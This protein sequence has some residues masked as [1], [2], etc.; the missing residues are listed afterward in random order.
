MRLPARL[1]LA[2][3]G[4]AAVL[5]IAA[6]PADALEA[7]ELDRTADSYRSE[8]VEAAAD[9]DTAPPAVELFRNAK[10]AALDGRL[11]DAVA[12]YQLLVG[13]RPAD[14]DAWLRLA[15]V[16]AER[17]PLSPLGLAAAYNA[18][19]LAEGDALRRADALL[20]IAEALEDQ[21]RYRLATEVFD[22]LS[23]L[24][25][26]DPTFAERRDWLRRQYGFH[27]EETTVAFE[28]DRP[29][30]CLNFSDP[31]QPARL[32]HYADYVRIAPEVP[33]E[34]LA[35]DRALC[36][37]GVSHGER[38]TVTVLS[39]LP[40]ADGERLIGDDVFAR[41]VDEREPQVGF[42][43]DTY[44]LPRGG[45]ATAPLTT[46][47]VAEVELQLLRINDRGLMEQIVEDRIGATVDGYDIREIAENRGE[48]IWQGEMAIE[49]VANRSVTTGVPLGELVEDIAPGIYILAARDADD[50]ERW[51]YE[52]RGTQWVVLSDLGLVTYTGHDGL[53]VAVRSLADGRALAGV[54]VRL[55]A[56]N[57]AQLGEAV[58]DADGLA[59]FEAGLVAGTGGSRPGAVLAYADGADAEDFNFLA[60]T[61]PAFDLSDRGVSGRAEPGPLDA[62]LYTERSVYRP[63]ET[64]HLTTLLRDERADALPG[65]PITVTLTR[66]D[67]IEA[68][69]VR[70]SDQGDGG[71]AAALALSDSAR[72]GTWTAAAFVDPDG[73]AIGRVS[74]QVEDF[75]PLRLR[76]DLEPAAEAI[77]PGALT[78]IDVTA[79][80]LY[81]APAVGLPGEAELVLSPAARPFIAD[82]GDWTSWR[83]GL[84]Q[85][86]LEPERLWLDLPATDAEGASAVPVL[87]D[88]L[89]D[90]TLPLQAEIRT[91]LFDVGGRPV[92]RAVTLPVQSGD[93]WIGL[94]AEAGGAFAEDS[95]AS[96]EVI[97]LD[98]D[99]ARTAADALRYQL[100][101]EV[102][103]Y[104]WF[105][106]DGV[107]D[108]RVVVRDRVL[109]VGEVAVAADGPAR[110]DEP[111]DWG[112]YRLDVFEAAGGAAS[113]VRFHAG[114][115]ARP[116]GEETPDTL[117]VTVDRD[118]YDTGDTL[119]VHLDAPF[120]G[121]ALVMVAND[122]LLHAQNVAIGE[123][124]AQLAIPVGEDW[125]VGAYVLATGFRPADADERARGPGRAVGVAWFALDTAD[126]T[127]DVA[128][129]A[130]A[131]IRPR[132]DIT[133]PVSVGGLGEGDQAYVTLAAVDEGILLLTDFASPDP[134]DHYFG[135]RALGL[136][137][138]DAYG[139]LIVSDGRRGRV[140]SGGDG[141]QL[142]GL[143][144]RIVE[145]V[146]LFSGIVPVGADGSAEIPLEIPD[147]NGELRLMA[148]AWTARGIG[149][150]SQPLTVRDP[151]VSQVALPRFLAPDDRAAIMLSLHNVDGPA[152]DYSVAVTGGGAVTVPD[153]GTFV[154]PLGEDERY[155]TAVPLSAETLGVGEITLALAGPDDF[156]ITRRWQIAVRPPQPY[157]TDRLSGLLPPG[158]ALVVDE[159][160]AQSY[161]PGTT[162][163]SASF[164]TRPN[165]DVPG[166]LRQLDGYA[167]GCLEQ[168]VSRALP[169][170][171][172][173]EVAER[174][175]DDYRPDDIRRR[176]QQ[177]VNRT[178]AM[179]QRGGSFGIWGPFGQTNPWLDAYAMD[180]LTRA[181]AEGFDVPDSA[182][183]L[184]LTAL[185]GYVNRWDTRDE[186]HDTAAAALYTLAR[187]DE[188]SV[189]DLRY[190]A[191]TCTGRFRTP[192]ASAQLAA[193]LAAYGETERSGTLFAEASTTERVQPV[194]LTHTDYGSGLRDQAALVA[195]QAE[196]GRPLEEVLSAADHV[197]ALF[198]D[199]RYTSTQE[200]AWLLMAAHALLDTQDEMLLSIDGA[201]VPPTGA[202]VELYPTAAELAA[203]LRVVNDGEDPV[204]R[205]ITVR[206][207]PADPL[208]A[209]SNG[210]TIAREY[211]TLDGRVIDPT[212]EPVRQN[213]LLVVVLTGTK[214]TELHQDALIVDRLPAGFEIENPNIG[215]GRG[216][217][218]L[219]ASLDLSF[220][221]H[222]EQR[223]DRYVAALTLWETLETFRVAYLVRAVTPGD[224]VLPGPFVEDMYRPAYNARGE[225]ARVTVL[226]HDG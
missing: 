186:C 156:A 8:L 149:G 137:M 105:S 100:V 63:G 61:G 25:P 199:R 123:D 92:N 172:L 167:Y 216:L 35:E 45:A 83:F 224:F 58:S 119:S 126:R 23:R 173:S 131:E 53:H 165:F 26:E 46:V 79:D 110:I 66:P 222:V 9:L 59:L 135:R 29:Q 193:A 179:Q 99:G 192:V 221:E 177:A 197:G 113:S 154:L 97:A 225:T 169:M 122:R 139:R 43:G 109:A 55:L 211:R 168:T 171:Y 133:V 201:P 198:A 129:D 203:G 28:R 42:R 41:D 52:P 212:A 75:V 106:V 118:T 74:F 226:P 202:A 44:I 18:Y 81:G 50:R 76:L 33:I 49:S 3:A 200:Q 32:V 159:G 10:Q 77:R 47:N 209:A 82:G 30:I 20:L 16:W 153:A 48:L 101:R 162:T 78:P 21:Q 166:L 115:W 65:V 85:E 1:R 70:L 183:R 213:D 141:D 143:S 120:A 98:G 102:Y 117:Q 114:W 96:V 87:I 144:V 57:N 89:P 164:S 111:V 108:Y 191:D 80:Y 134:T 7:P 24:L 132:Q 68:D 11:G 86:E 158:A 146:A 67:G 38:Y 34:V 205:V 71:Y 181:R 163:V 37:E 112:T 170:L 19:D 124:G 210:L 148:V 27:I 39:G 187:A 12:A 152:G 147:Y 196:A 94:R 160:P 218:D 51:L 69:S 60:L 150:A 125:G 84:V 194:S 189:A 157:V 136:E 207:I 182:W 140:R 95:V 214:A 128:I 54:T 176:L 188:A 204:R 121:E 116:I 104:Q 185:Q 138:R 107:W 4:L 40:S 127:L 142:G 145:T 190:F 56:R 31:L 14:G 91:S 151:L 17:D 130:P 15:A 175:G 215:D 62:W 90:T 72:T 195:L 36:I 178:L 64:V 103:D 161:V 73:E 6:A 93:L 208:P 13:L 217:E 88:G 223:D 180:F 206:G 174:W 184:G 220:P 22:E 155:A 2:A 5:V 219:A